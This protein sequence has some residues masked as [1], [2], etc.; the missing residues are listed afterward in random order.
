[1][2]TGGN[3]FFSTI[4]ATLEGLR[5]YTIYPDGQKEASFIPIINSSLA[6]SDKILMISAL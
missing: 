4:S 3:V 2:G 5:S 6:N 1:M